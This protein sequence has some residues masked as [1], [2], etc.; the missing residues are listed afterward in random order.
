MKPLIA[1]LCGSLAL[2]GTA[3]AAP[4]VMLSG[5]GYYDAERVVLNVFADSAVQL[6]SFGILLSYHPEEVAEPAV[7]ANHALWFLSAQPGQR[8]AYTPALLTERSVRIVGARFQGEA[9]GNGVQGRE[10]LLATL[11]FPRTGETLPSFGIDLAGPELYAS[12]VA[13][14][15]SHIDDQ[16]DGLG[17]LALGMEELPLDTDHDGIPDPVE[18]AWFNNLTRATATSDNDGDGTP[19]IDEWIGGTDPKDPASLTRLVLQMQPDGSRRLSWTGQSGRIY[20]VLKSTDLGTF[21]PLAEGLTA[22]SPTI[23]F[24]LA[25]HGQGFYSLRTQL[26]SVGH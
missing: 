21:I 1:I 13:I 12:F 4:S 17:T 26:P 15:G 8:S 10:L 23:V 14:D 22:E 2:A 25:P 19:D 16:V 18:L 3:A 6:R 5:K 11:V 20:D 7:F 24:D 9:P